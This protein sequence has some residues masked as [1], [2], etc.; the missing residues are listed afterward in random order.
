MSW[1]APHTAEAVRNSISETSSNRLR[2]SRSP[3]L[4]HSGVLAAA[5]TTYAATT[6]ETSVSR[7]RSWAIVGSAVARIVWSS[8]A[9][10]IA[11]TIAANA[12]RSSRMGVVDS[13][14]SKA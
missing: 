12:I 1:A 5:V 11:S 7:P 10:S 14:M 2:P 3:S 6:H 4:P 13:F 8:T 9:G